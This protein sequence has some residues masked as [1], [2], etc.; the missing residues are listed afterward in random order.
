M[1]R[2]GCM[3]IQEQATKCRSVIASTADASSPTAPA[4]CGAR[5]NGALQDSGTQLRP[6]FEL[7]GARACGGWSALV[8]ADQ[9]QVLGDVGQGLALDAS[10]VRA[11]TE[12]SSRF[13]V[14]H[15][16]H[17]HPGCDRAD[18]AL[19]LGSDDV[20][21][22]GRAVTTRSSTETSSTFTAA[23]AGDIAEAGSIDT[24]SLKQL[25]RVDERHPRRVKGIP[26]TTEIQSPSV[27]AAGELLRFLG[28][29][30]AERRASAR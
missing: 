27:P 13:R 23:A 7:V 24:L 4:S 18:P 15:G 11:A 26:L 25:R 19:R 28:H 20:Q 5:H 22:G 3:P 12:D 9:G 21:A 10:V 2:S 8:P 1:P 17:C 14:G 6:G 29:P 16:S 30:R